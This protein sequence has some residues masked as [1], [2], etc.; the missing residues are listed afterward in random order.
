MP[1]RIRPGREE[2]REESLTAWAGLLKDLFPSGAP[3]SAQWK[4]D[5]SSMSAIL[6]QIASPP[7]TNHLFFPSG[8]GMDLL[9]AMP[10]DEE[11]GC[12]ALRTGDNSFEVLKPSV[13]LFEAVGSEP[14]WAY[15]RLESEPL[16][17]CGVYDDEEEADNEEGNENDGDQTESSRKRRKI[18]ELVRK[19]EEVVLVAPGIYAPRSA[20]D[21]NEYEAEPLPETAQLVSRFLS[22]D[23]FVIFA[24]GSL[25]NMG[26]YRNFDA[27][28]PEYANQPAADFRKFIEK[29][30]EL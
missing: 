18:K 30:S 29:L 14:D 10:F 2:F 24:K 25:Y 23:P 27:Y 28:D 17:P 20:W 16:K 6:N 15:F 1:V 13:L 7:R 26:R 22:G 9:E 19:S 21:A 8:G 12:L 4:G 3:T 11:A 5:L